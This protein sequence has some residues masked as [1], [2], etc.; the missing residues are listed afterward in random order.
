MKFVAVLNFCVL[1]FFV[2]CKDCD[3]RENYYKEVSS[4]EESES[5]SKELE[6]SE[7]SSEYSEDSESKTSSIEAGTSVDSDAEE[8]DEHPQ[9]LENNERIVSE[10]DLLKEN[11]W[12]TERSNCNNYA[13]SSKLRCE[14]QCGQCMTYCKAANI[15]KQSLDCGKNKICC[16]LTRRKNER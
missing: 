1:A 11:G 7:E 8:I 16:V 9:D 10:E 14:Q 12:I 4:S 2:C 3:G 5:E 13:N 6:S 15:R